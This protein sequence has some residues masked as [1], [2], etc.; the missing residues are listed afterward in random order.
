[1]NGKALTLATVA[2]EYGAEPTRAI[3]PEFDYGGQT[4]SHSSR[5]CRFHGGP[6]AVRDP[7]ASR[8]AAKAIDLAMLVF[9]RLVSA[10]PQA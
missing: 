1:M 6:V 5:S 3:E 10:M 7:K 8:A 2:Y 9:L 4:V